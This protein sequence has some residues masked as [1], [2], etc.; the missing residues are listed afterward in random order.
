[1]RGLAHVFVEELFERA[2]IRMQWARQKRD[3]EERV[4][5]VF[6]LKHETRK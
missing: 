5:H 1:L 6:R 3:L 2:A 4:Q